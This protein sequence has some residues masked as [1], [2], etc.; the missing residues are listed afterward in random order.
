MN[1]GIL[2]LHPTEF[3]CPHCGEWHQLSG[4]V[5]LGSPDLTLHCKHHP[6]IDYSFTLTEQDDHK[7]EK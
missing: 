3:F 1:A 5:E 2:K 7:K 4:D 6:N